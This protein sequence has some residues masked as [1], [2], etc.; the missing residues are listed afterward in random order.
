LVNADCAS[1]ISQP[2]CYFVLRRQMSECPIQ[3]RRG[4]QDGKRSRSYNSRQQE[5][6][7]RG[8]VRIA[9]TARITAPQISA[10]LDHKPAAASI[11][12]TAPAPMIATYHQYGALP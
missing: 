8:S 1:H 3:A 4:P 11:G 7:C 12:G 6:A 9:A 10:D 5:H 2:F